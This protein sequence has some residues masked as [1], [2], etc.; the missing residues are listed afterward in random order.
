MYF[1]TLFSF[2]LVIFTLSNNAISSNPY[3][4]ENKTYNTD[5]AYFYDH[6]ANFYSFDVIHNTG[7][8]PKIF[9]SNPIYIFL[10]DLKDD[11]CNVLQPSIIDF[12]PGD[13]GYSDFKQVVIV[14]G[15]KDNDS[16]ITCYEDLKRLG[17]KV[18]LY[19]TDIYL[20]LPVVGFSSK[21]E[22]PD[23]GPAKLG[24][25][26]G[27]PVR[28]FD[29]GINPAGNATADLFHAVSKNYTRLANLPSTI[30]GLKDYSAMWIVFNLTV[31]KPLK[32]ITSLDQ[33]SDITPVYINA[34]V[35]CPVSITILEKKLN[36]Y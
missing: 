3:D 36:R 15:R 7:K 14:I 35:N 19:F 1:K 30:P 32:E 28:Y 24:Y 10:K 12:I 6:P 18:K 29:F 25:Y 22:Y 8:P 9:D 33:L 34:I 11:I 4:L 31:V 20:N 16:H 27:G 5:V 13:E 17:R 21:L 26:N 23:D 2:A